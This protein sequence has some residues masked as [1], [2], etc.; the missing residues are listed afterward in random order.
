MSLRQWSILLQLKFGAYNSTKIESNLKRIE[1][2]QSI[3]KVLDDFNDTVATIFA[4]NK[5]LLRKDGIA[6][7]DF[8]LL[9]GSFAIA[10]GLII[11]TNNIEHFRRIPKV[12]IENWV[13]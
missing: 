7:G 4:K 9:I 11:V 10:N 1:K 12:Q 3:L 5:A 8:D 13:E 2:L 6:I